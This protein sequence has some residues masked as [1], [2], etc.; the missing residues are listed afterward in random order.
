MGVRN[1]T[2]TEP[3]LSDDMEL[4]EYTIIEKIFYKVHSY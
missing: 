1:I 3:K 2:V 4:F